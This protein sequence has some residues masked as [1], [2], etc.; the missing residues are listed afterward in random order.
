M[1]KNGKKIKIKSNLNYNS[2]IGTINNKNPKSVYFVISAWGKPNYDDEINYK[3]VISKLNKKIKTCL[4]NNL[5]ESLFNNKFIVDFDMRYSGISKGKKSFMSCEVNL[6]KN[7][8]FGIND[9]RIKS[10]LESIINIIIDEVFDKS[11]DFNFT[12]KK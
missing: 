9:K 12:P 8:T 11:E 5:D 6:Y 2:Y 1:V 4:Y 7:N 3:S 10:E